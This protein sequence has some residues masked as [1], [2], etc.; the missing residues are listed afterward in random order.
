VPVLTLDV[1][2]DRLIKRGRAFWGVTVCAGP[3]ISMALCAW[4]YTNIYSPFFVF[5]RDRE[6][7][8]RCSVWLRMG[9]CLCVCV[10]LFVQVGR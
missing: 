3:S 10:D 8:G 9:V 5:A 2:P 6:S 7:T 4:V 1:H